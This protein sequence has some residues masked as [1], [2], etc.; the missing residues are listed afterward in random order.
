MAFFWAESSRGSLRAGRW[1]FAEL[2]EVVDELQAGLG[3]S[4]PPYG[5]P[6]PIPKRAQAAGR[7][8]HVAWMRKAASF[9]SFLLL[10]D[11][12][13]ECETVEAFS[14]SRKNWA[15]DGE[16]SEA[17]EKRTH[18]W[19]AC[20]DAKPHCFFSFASQGLVSL[21]ESSFELNGQDWRERDTLPAPS[22]PTLYRRRRSGPLLPD[23]LECKVRVGGN[24][25]A[26]GAPGALSVQGTPRGGGT[27]AKTHESP[28]THAPVLLIPR[29]NQ[30]E[31][32]LCV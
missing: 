21:S 12:P 19:G 16:S 32:A 22:N 29:Q 9:S 3:S 30:E 24:V 17:E 20:E 23:P 14:K 10:Q 5:L 25:S 4:S 31:Q 2:A 1:S 11:F 7:R 8:P 13:A 27:K 15:S 26:R 6:F 28:G 18:S